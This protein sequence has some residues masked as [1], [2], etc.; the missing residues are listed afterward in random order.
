MSSPEVVT[1]LIDEISSLVSPVPVLDL[2]EYTRLDD[3][4]GDAQ[5]C[6]LVDVAAS[7]ERISS[8]GDPD[9]LGFQEDGTILL[10]WLYTN[11][12]PAAPVKAKAAALRL[13][14]RGRRIGEV[15]IEAVHPFKRAGTS[16]DL[17]SRFSAFTAILSYS[18]N[19]CA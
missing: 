19:T 9:S 18:T 13:A 4:P 11:G 14:L 1:V 15:W 6:V 2:D 12:F 3:L 5:E 17:S 16:V 10:H 7:T 8:I